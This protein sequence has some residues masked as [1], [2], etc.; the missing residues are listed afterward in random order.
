MPGRFRFPFEKLHKIR[1]FQTREAQ[2]IL[3]ESLSKLNSRIDDLYQLNM[4]AK[5]EMEKLLGVIATGRMD[6][7]SAE[8]IVGSLENNKIETDICRNDIIE[9]EKEVEEK[10]DLLRGAVKEEKKFSKY[11]DRL[12]ENY[13]KGEGRRLM[14]E[15]D[16][17]ASR[18]VSGEKREKV[19]S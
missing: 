1:S 3:G 13:R 5:L 10:R 4:A 18:V 14:K 12:F 17:I 11:R 16:E 9:I 2:R 7:D 8:M 15:I 6:M 19:M